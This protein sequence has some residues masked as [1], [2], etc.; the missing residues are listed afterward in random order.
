M[1]DAVRIFEML[2]CNKSAEYYR[3]TTEC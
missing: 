1:E 3:N 2:G